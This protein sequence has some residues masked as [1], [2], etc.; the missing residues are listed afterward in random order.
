MILGLTTTNESGVAVGWAMGVR[1]IKA[2]NRN[3]AIQPASKFGLGAI[4]ER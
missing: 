2:A 1:W 4:S 3:R